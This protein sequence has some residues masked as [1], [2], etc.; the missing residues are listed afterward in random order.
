MRLVNCLKKVSLQTKTIFKTYNDS[1]SKLCACLLLKVVNYFDSEKFQHLEVR[2][3]WNSHFINVHASVHE[4]AFEF[5]LWNVYIFK[6]PLVTIGI[7]FGLHGSFC[8]MYQSKL[9]LFF[10]NS[11][12]PLEINTVWEKRNIKIPSVIGLPAF[13]NI[14]PVVSR[15]MLA[16]FSFYWSQVFSRVNTVTNLGKWLQSQK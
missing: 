9:H 10:L 3:L 8:V 6:L 1:C 11:T 14:E 12:T 15:E 16:W 7:K 5:I 13:Q 4:I 2:C